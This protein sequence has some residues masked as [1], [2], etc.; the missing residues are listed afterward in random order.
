MINKL[1]LTWAIGPSSLNRNEALLLRFLV[2]CADD[3]YKCFPSVGT[4]TEQTKMCE[5]S[6]KKAINSLI[7][8]GLVR[9]QFR[10]S[11]ENGQQRSNY[12]FLSASLFSGTKEAIT[13]YINRARKA[14]LLKENSKQKEMELPLTACSAHEDISPCNSIQ[15]GQHKRENMKTRLNNHLIN[16]YRNISKLLTKTKNK[17][18]AFTAPRDNH[19]KI[20]LGL[21]KKLFYLKNKIH[22]E[23][24]LFFDNVNG[25]SQDNVINYSF[26]SLKKKKYITSKD[27]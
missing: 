26:Y 20:H 3:N 4:I 21:F 27:V 25:G 13:N 11:K 10:F 17:Y 14:W 15:K 5:T 7:G 2:L 6:Y 16:T 9:R 19:V 18:I 22:S 1:E 24:Q 8:M 12:F 23:R